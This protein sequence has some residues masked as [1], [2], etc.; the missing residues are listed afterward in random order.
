M[1]PSMWEYSTLSPIIRETSQ[2]RLRTHSNRHCRPKRSNRTRL[3]N[4]E[5]GNS[6]DVISISASLLVGYTFSGGRGTSLSGLRRLD[7]FKSALDPYT[8]MCINTSYG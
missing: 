1:Q 4:Q 5:A 7:D 2:R 6:S 8:S 3:P